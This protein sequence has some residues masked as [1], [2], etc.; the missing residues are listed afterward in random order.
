MTR[1]GDRQPAS[2][3]AALDSLARAYSITRTAPSAPT[4]V[5]LDENLQEQPLPEPPAI[6]DVSRDRSPRSHG[7]DAL[8]VRT[9]LEFLGRARR[10]LFLMSAAC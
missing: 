10:P 7:P 2:V 5:C 4:Y 3:E 9:A 1:G 6:P 8:A